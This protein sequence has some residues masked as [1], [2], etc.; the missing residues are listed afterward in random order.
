MR[1]RIRQRLRRLD[2]FVEPADADEGQAGL[3]VRDETEDEHVLVVFLDRRYPLAG[4]MRAGLV[5]LAGAAIS[6]LTAAA[7]LAF[8]GLPLFLALLGGCAL[9]ALVGWN[10]GTV[11]ESGLRIQY[12]DRLLTAVDEFQRMV[13]FGMSTAEAF[14]AAAAAAEEPV[15]GSLRRVRDSASLGVP[16]AVALDREAQRVRVSEL[17]MLAAIFATQAHVG[18]GL[19][20]SV[21]NLADMLRERKDNR[22]RLKAATAESKLSLIVLSAVPFAAVGIQGAAKP[23]IF[24]VLLGDARHLLGIGMGLVV[25]GLVSAW[26]LVRG[27]RQ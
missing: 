21:G 4:G 20:E 13:R 6:G 16:L 5:A 27:V 8:F 11:L 25:L 18:G 15:V 19:A 9:G 10:V 2:L 23:E 3:P 7:A 26:L 24:G 17:A 12:A 1:L 14:H 22:A